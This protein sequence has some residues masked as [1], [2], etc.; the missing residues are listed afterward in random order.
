MFSLDM[1][2]DTVKI[3]KKEIENKFLE[4]LCV[5]TTTMNSI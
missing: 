3:L 5:L 2:M 4:N 1:A